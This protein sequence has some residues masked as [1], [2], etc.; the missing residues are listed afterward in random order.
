MQKHKFLTLILVLLIS[1]PTLLFAQNDKDKIN[2][3]TQL[4]VPNTSIKMNIPDA[5]V[6]DLEQSAFIYS[7]AAA[8]ISFKEVKGTSVKTLT[9][10]MRSAL[11]NEAN[12]QSNTSTDLTT[13]AG[14]TA[15][16][17]IT[18]FA[19]TANGQEKQTEFERIVFVCGNEDNAVWVSVSYPAMTRSLLSDV[20]QSCLLSI[21]F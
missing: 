10:S 7:G 19:V 14:A 5:F 15:T 13:T 6:W 3:F 18:T 16:Q 21:E 8:S 11:R 17:F 1:L 20:L 9:E 12:I 2:K 4:S